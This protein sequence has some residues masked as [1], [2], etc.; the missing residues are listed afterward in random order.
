M[1]AS[2]AFNV[3]KSIVD[4]LISGLKLDDALGTAG[5]GI[6]PPPAIVE[7]VEKVCSDVLSGLLSDVELQG[8][9]LRFLDQFKLGNVPPRNLRQEW[10]KRMISLLDKPGFARKISAIHGMAA[11]L[12]RFARPDSWYWPVCI[13][14]TLRHEPK[15]AK[16]L[17]ASNVYAPL[18][19]MGGINMKR[20]ETRNFARLALTRLGQL[21]G[22]R[23]VFSKIL[24]ADWSKDISAEDIS[25][26]FMLG[27]FADG[28]STAH[29]L[30]DN[31][32]AHKKIL[33]TTRSF[34]DKRS[35]ADT[36]Y[37]KLDKGMRLKVRSDPWLP[38]LRS[39]GTLL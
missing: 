17:A 3:C 9:E 2:D 20:E 7:D 34:E 29:K 11:M 21:L 13:V 15:M 10:L 30:F 23:S 18:F 27:S 25:V 28:W 4:D 14:K 36:L 39:C 33:V 6:L 8:D 19:H 32:N 1:T 16:E 12:V 22:M 26:P 37:D 31:L 24:V 5:T 35:F 38:A